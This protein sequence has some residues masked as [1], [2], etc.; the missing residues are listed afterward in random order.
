LRLDWQPVARFK[1]NSGYLVK[2]AETSPFESSARILNPALN[3][4]TIILQAGGDIFHQDP[5][6]VKSLYYQS[7]PDLYMGLTTLRSNGRA[8]VS[9]DPVALAILSHGRTADEMIAGQKSGRT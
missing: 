2:P 8:F 6:L 3:P 5:P 1:A 7:S 9:R 4:V